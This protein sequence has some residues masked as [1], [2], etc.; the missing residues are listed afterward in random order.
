M[1]AA[2]LTDEEIART[3]QEGDIEGF[4]ELVERYEAKLLRYGRKFLPRTEDIEDIVQDAFVSA[5]QNIKS[6]DTSRRFSPWIYQIAH[7]AFVNA[8]RKHSRNPLTMV[9]FDTFLSYH[10]EEAPTDMERE[11]KEMRELIEKGLD[12]L[13][14]KSREILVLFYLEDFSYTEIA[15]ILQV[16]VG[17]VGV[18]LKRAREQLRQVYEKM[19]MTYGE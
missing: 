9:D 3:V 6:F 2:P 13:S 11:H 1:S 19:N 17:T 16:P 5:F 15:D 12:E 18:R 10:V 7:N 14:P 4:G 8:L